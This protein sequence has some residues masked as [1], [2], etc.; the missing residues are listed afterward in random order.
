[1]LSGAGVVVL[2]RGWLMSERAAEGHPL[3]GHRSHPVC[4]LI[5]AALW[6]PFSGS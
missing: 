4:A 5:G 1:M 6:T 2:F 3:V